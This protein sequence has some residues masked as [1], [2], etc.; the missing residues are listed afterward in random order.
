MGEHLK[1]IPHDDSHNCKGKTNLIYFDNSTLN[2][3]TLFEMAKEFYKEKTKSNLKMSYQSYDQYYLSKFSYNVRKPK[4]DV[5]D[6]G[7]EC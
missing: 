4:T 6:F 1:T 2:V 5:C 7:K 3:K